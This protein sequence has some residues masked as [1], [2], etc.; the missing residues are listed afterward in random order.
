MAW[1]FSSSTTLN[2]PTPVAVPSTGLAP[3]APTKKPDCQCRA[4]G[5]KYELGETTCFSTNKGLVRARCELVLNNTSWKIL[6]G[7]CDTASIEMM[8]SP[9]LRHHDRSSM[10]QCL[11]S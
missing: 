3:G 1:G 2:A 4:N 11:A 10:S 8:Q 6:Q 5:L 7:S 9:K